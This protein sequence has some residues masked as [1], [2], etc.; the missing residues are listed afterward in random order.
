[1][2]EYKDYGWIDN[3]FTDAHALFMNPIIKMLPTDYSPILD[4]GCGNGSFAIHLIKNGYNVYGTDASLKGINIGN[5]ITPN[6]FFIQDFSSDEL[7]AELA[8]IKFKTIIS[9]EVIEHLYDPRRYMG[10]CKKIL[11]TS[12]GGDLFLS[13]PYHGYLKNLALAICGG[14]DRHYTALWDGGHIKFWSK[15]TITKLLSEQGFQLDEF[16]G[17]GRLPYFWKSMII[18]SKILPKDEQIQ[19]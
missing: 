4:L 16:T 12:G 13:T 10:L 17:C 9:T 7:P 6:R 2:S 11:L 18:R 1:M 19:S 8:A 5:S 15:G 14:M 3:G